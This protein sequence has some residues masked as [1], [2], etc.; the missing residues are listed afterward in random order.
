[1]QEQTEQLRVRLPKSLFKLIKFYVDYYG[2]DRSKAVRELLLEGLVR[3]SYIGLLERLTENLR[4]KHPDP[5]M[6]QHECEK[7]NRKTKLR[8]Y[9]IDGNVRNLEPKNLII[10][11]EDCQ[12]G[13]RRFIQKYDPKERFVAWYYSK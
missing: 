3:T 7:C 2:T 1:M 11:C 12:I 10:L 8:I 13:L 9:H 5:M 6:D 4:N